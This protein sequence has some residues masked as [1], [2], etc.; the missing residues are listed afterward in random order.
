M[1]GQKAALLHQ[2]L[3][4]HKLEGPSRPFPTF[5]S[6]AKMLICVPAYVQQQMLAQRLKTGLVMSEGC[7]SGWSLC[8]CAARVNG[9]ARCCF[10]DWE[11]NE[12]RRGKKKNNHQQKQKEK[13]NLKRKKKIRKNIQG[14]NVKKNKVKGENKRK[15][16][17]SENEGKLGKKGGK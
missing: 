14:K 17:R 12:R 10:R 7:S 9:L 6:F 4:H 13:R 8:A 3:G 16:A 2:I 15:G 1:W 5:I 11:I